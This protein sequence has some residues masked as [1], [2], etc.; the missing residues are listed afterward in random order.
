MAV[1][2]GDVIYK[3]RQEIGLSQEKLGELCGLS[4]SAIC[5]IENGRRT[6]SAATLC[7]LA[8][9]LGLPKIEL[10][11]AGGYLNEIDVTDYSQKKYRESLP[12]SP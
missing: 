3:A 8:P 10:L 11:I 9:H 2:I 7:A 5:K 6:P 4:H 12:E 1:R